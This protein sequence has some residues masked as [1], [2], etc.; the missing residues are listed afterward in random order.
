MPAGAPSAQFSEFKPLLAV[1]HDCRFVRPDGDIYST[2]TTLYWL[3]TGIGIKRLIPALPVC[4]EVACRYSFVHIARY[5]AASCG[6][7]GTSSVMSVQHLVPI[8]SLPNAGGSL[9]RM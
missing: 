8:C 5:Q 4:K 7:S 2:G 1:F 9:H 6:A 3:S